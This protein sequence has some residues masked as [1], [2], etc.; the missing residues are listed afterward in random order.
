MFVIFSITRTHTV[1]E[2]SYTSLP[3]FLTEFVLAHLAYT[4]SS[5]SSDLLFQE[6]RSLGRE[7][8]VITCIDLPYVIFLNE[9]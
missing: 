3:C 5:N 1:K 9:L 7:P 6:V 4:L 8:Q 2:N